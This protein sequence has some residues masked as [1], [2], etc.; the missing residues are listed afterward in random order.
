MGI[1]EDYVMKKIIIVGAGPSGLHAAYKLADT[2]EVHL[3]EKM[4]R[5]QLLYE[6][7]WTDSI[8]LETLPLLSLKT[9]IKKGVRFYGEGVKNREDR[10]GI[11]EPMKKSSAPRIAVDRNALIAH[12]LSRVED[13]IQIHYGCDVQGILGNCEGTLAQHKVEGIIYK[14]EQAKKEMDAD[15]V[16]DASGAAFALRYQFTSCLGEKVWKDDIF[17]AYK[18]MRKLTSEEALKKYSNGELIHSPKGYR[19]IS[20]LDEDILDVG[21]CI[22]SDVKDVMAA[23]KEAE[24]MISKMEG[25]KEESFGGGG[26]VIPMTLPIASLVCNSFACVGENA[27]MTNPGNG[28]GI[29]GAVLGAEILGNIILKNNDFSI[30]G[31]WE[32]G[33]EW[34]SGRGAMYASN[35]FPSQFFEEEECKLL[36]AKNLITGTLKNSSVSVFADYCFNM[37]TENF[38]NLKQE[39]EILYEKVC[40]LKECSKDMFKVLINYPKAWDEET[41]TMWENAFREI[42]N[43]YYE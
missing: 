37:C 11:F 23:K 5:S 35:Y 30:A 6:H 39:N 34:F 36:K 9:P 43:R 32:Y 10:I 15:L 31:L 28:C 29:S 2:Y 24:Y 41:F 38:Y 4:Q 12:L 26:H 27:I 20:Q 8:D 16:I 3:F 1:K 13:K 33:Y 14:Q 40:K 7:P 17:S 22:V 19:W 25:V 42:K 21:C 18:T